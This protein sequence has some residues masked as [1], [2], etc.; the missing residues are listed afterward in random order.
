MTGR[1]HGHGGPTTAE[2]AAPGQPAKKDPTVAELIG[3]AISNAP[4]PTGARRMFAASLGGMGILAASVWSWASDVTARQA[5]QEAQQKSLEKTL[6]EQLPGMTSKINEIDRN[7]A[8]GDARDGERDRRLE[9][10]ERNLERI[11]QKLDE[12]PKRL[13]K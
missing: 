4:M 9:R 2:V 1:A 10:V 12:L 5:T 7:N 11:E 13:G 3:E 6:S 8:A